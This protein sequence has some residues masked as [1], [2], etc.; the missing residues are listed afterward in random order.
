M[1]VQNLATLSGWSS[2]SLGATSLCFGS[3]C[4][5][6][7][8]VPTSSF[9]V[10]ARHLNSGKNPTYIA[11]NSPTETP[12]QPLNSQYILVI[13]RLDFLQTLYVCGCQTNK[14]A[15]KQTNHAWQAHLRHGFEAL[16]RQSPPPALSWTDI[17][18]ERQPCFCMDIHFSAFFKL[19]PFV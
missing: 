7:G 6:P 19:R 16:R 3:L 4:C 15:N 17:S 5:D 1:Y 11:G 10:N 2:S 13:S 12:F 8:K 18:S 9:Y 14:Q